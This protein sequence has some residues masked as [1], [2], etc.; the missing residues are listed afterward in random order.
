MQNLVL[1]HQA[2]KFQWLLLLLL[3]LLLA[4][5]QYGDTSCPNSTAN[6]DTKPLYLLALLAMYDGVESDIL[7]AKIAKRKSTIA[8]TSFLA[9]I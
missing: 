9:T 1:L 8:V 3:I 6:G 7:A 4:T 5:F 2:K